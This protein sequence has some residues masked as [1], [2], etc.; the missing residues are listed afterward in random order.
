MFIAGA[1][2]GLLNPAGSK[3]VYSWFPPQRRAIALSIKQ[4]SLPL[5]GV[6]GGLLLPSLAIMIGWRKSWMAAGLAT[7]ATAV[8]TKLIYR[9]PPLRGPSATGKA[10]F[11]V[12]AIGLLQHGTI[13]RLSLLA[14]LLTGIQICW[15]GY[16]TLFLK[17]YFGVS[18]VPAGTYLALMQACAILGRPAQGI[19]SDTLFGSSRRGVLILVGIISF[20]MG[21]CIALIP[22]TA[23]MWMVAWILVVIGFTAISWHGVHLAWM[24]E[25]AGPA[26]AGAASGLWIGS[27]HFAI[28]LV[29]PIFGAIVDSSGS[30]TPGW[31]FTSLLSALATVILFSVRTSGKEETAG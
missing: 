16:I 22:K 3:A 30:Y 28:I 9:E 14:F 21:I 4:T 11:P 15:H 1:G 6:L 8:F 27:C 20:F 25:I 5:C 26:T 7:L 29:S 31:L 24:T 17:D 19:V 18:A 23:P 10:A 2:Y 12:S 13:L